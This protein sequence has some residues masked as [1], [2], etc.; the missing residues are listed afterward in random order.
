MKS[1]PTRFWWTMIALGWALDFLFWQK[2]PGI[3]F[4]LYALL[5][6]TVG[7]LILRADGY[8]PARKTLLLLPLIA[9]FA[10]MTFIRLEPMTAFL[11]IVLT[12][13]LMGLFAISF[14]GGRWPAYNLLDYLNGFL[15]LAG[16]MVARPLG[17]SAEVKRE[18]SANGESL[19]GEVKGRGASQVWPVVRG[20][21]IALPIVAIF[22]A[23][24]GSAD[25]IFGQRLENLIQ[26]FKLEKLPEYIFRL[27]Y[28]LVGAYA[29]AGVFLHA[30]SQSKDEK[31]VG[32]EKPVV[33]TFLGFTESAIVLGSVA[34][35][36]AAFVFIQF[37]YFFGGQANI[38]IDGY[39]YS[40]YTRRGFGELVAVAFFSLLLILSASS[41][42]RRETDTQRRVFSGLGI[43]IVGLVI[44]MLVSAFQRLLL[45]EAAY[46]FSRLRTYTHVFILWLALL[47]VAVVVLEI[48]RRE[49]AFALAALIAVVGFSLSLGLMNVDGFIV[50]Q[51]VDRAVQ[52]ESFDV[53]YLTSLS[54]DSIPTLAAAYQTQSLPASVK[55]GVGAALACYATNQNRDS[56]SMPW[57]SFHFSRANATRILISLR[58]DLE[59]Y[60]TE[61]GDWSDSVLAPSG[62]EYRCNT[63]WD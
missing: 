2:A 41:V 51:N 10:I 33:P 25:V 36:F 12:L 48:L 7:I 22:A 20:I 8:R 62:E 30:A 26:L 44:V 9:F 57:Q 45:Y 6:L 4:A 23:L 35:L 21:L 39:T 46:G 55:E 24:L 29:L 60:Q 1:N 52:G 54:T 38:Q 16:S 18:A 58:A 28:I 3:N 49:R 19:Q 37:Q 13:F 17:F 32:E 42:T 34:V 47:L 50:R 14:L 59:Q 53:S 27:V 31:L 43:G 11:S 5:C 15:R 40:E 63:Y 61:D 56:N